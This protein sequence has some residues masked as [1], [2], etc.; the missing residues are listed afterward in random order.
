MKSGPVRLLIPALLF[1]A[2]P[3]HAQVAGAVETLAPV[4]AAEDARSWD[5]A[6]LRA[7][8]SSPDS[9]VRG[10]TALAV[11]RLGD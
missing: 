7:G 11:G 9:V 5:A 6:A 1:A 2:V 10:Q 3:A 4:L 8:L